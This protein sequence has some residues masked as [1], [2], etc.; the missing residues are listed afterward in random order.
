MF[1]HYKIILWHRQFT[2]FMIRSLRNDLFNYNGTQISW[3]F[4]FHCPLLELLTF[5]HAY[6]QFLGTYDKMMYSL[7]QYHFVEHQNNHDI[8]IPPIYHKPN[9]DVVLKKKDINPKVKI[10]FIFFRLTIIN[11]IGDIQNL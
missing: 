3:N 8:H 7:N 1:S 6:E 9:I 5:W 4:H 11:Y 10:Y 2:I